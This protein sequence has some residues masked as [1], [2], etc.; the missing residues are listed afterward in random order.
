MTMQ[1]WP[2]V[3]PALQEPGELCGLAVLP[4]LHWEGGDSSCPSAGRYKKPHHKRCSPWHSPG[5]TYSLCSGISAVLQPD[6]P[7]S[8]AL[9]FSEARLPWCLSIYNQLAKKK[10]YSFHFFI[11]S[12]LYSFSSGVIILSRVLQAI[13][14]VLYENSKT[15]SS[16]LE[17]LF[18][19]ILE[20]HLL[21]PWQHSF[22]SL[23]SSRV[24]QMQSEILILRPEELTLHHVLFV[25]VM[26][27]QRVF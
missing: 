27:H 25:P 13:P 9:S 4:V 5:A 1:L 24:H 10:T 16:L 14:D 3:K 2:E 23:V 15:V 11:Y 17:W 22:G 12:F 18:L 21:F 26:Q 19:Y 8:L 7:S 6:C 20:L